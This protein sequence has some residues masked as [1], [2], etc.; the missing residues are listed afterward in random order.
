MIAG[1]ADYPGY[2]N[3]PHGGVKGFYKLFSRGESLHGRKTLDGIDA[4]ILWGGMDVGSS[5]YGEECYLGPQHANN[6]PSHR[7]IFEWGLLKL[8]YEKGMPVIGVCRGAQLMCA[9]AGGKLAQ[10]V[11]GHHANHA[12][13]ASDGTIFNDVSSSHH[14]MMYPYDNTE[15][16]VLATTL[17]PLSAYYKGLTDNEAETVKQKGEPEVVYFPQLHGIAIQ[18]HPEWH[19]YDK[20]S[21][22]NSA[23]AEKFN[24]WLYSLIEQNLFK[25]K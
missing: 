18:S 20:W 14:Q 3:T 5:I 19:N 16:E 6:T 13:K 4:I 8:A 12:V 1:Y 25:G 10:D 24:D 9:F 2:G 11:S 15:H 17:S 21:S 22:S 7:D 23:G